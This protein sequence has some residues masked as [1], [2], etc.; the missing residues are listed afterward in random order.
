MFKVVLYDILL[1]FRMIA[2]ISE[3]PVYVKHGPSAYD[4]IPHDV[5]KMSVDMT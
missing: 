3:V 2:R 5:R 4:V 1:D